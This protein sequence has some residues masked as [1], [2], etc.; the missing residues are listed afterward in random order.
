MVDTASIVLDTPAPPKDWLDNDRFN[1]VRVIALEA[2]ERYPAS[3]RRRADLEEHYDSS[4]FDLD[5]QSLAQRQREKWTSVL[6][7][8]QPGYYGDLKQMRACLKLG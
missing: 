6:R 1:A 3:Q 7:Y 8:L 4:F 2:C 5:I